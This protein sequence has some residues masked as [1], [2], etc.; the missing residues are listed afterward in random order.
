MLDRN[1]QP[2]AKSRRPMIVVASC[3]G[4]PEGDK[5]RTRTVKKATVMPSPVKRVKKG[6][7]LNAAT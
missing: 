3:P 5:P 4:K 6:R 7:C 1:E 2:V